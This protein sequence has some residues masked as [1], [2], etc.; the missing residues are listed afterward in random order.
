M[1]LFEPTRMLVIKHEELTF[2]VVF[3]NLIIIVIGIIALG[4]EGWFG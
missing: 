1:I 3:V 4:M 2:P